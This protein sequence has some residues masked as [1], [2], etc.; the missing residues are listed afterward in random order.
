MAA[1]YRKILV[2]AWTTPATAGLSPL[3]RDV[4]H[5]AICANVLGILERTPAKIARLSCVPV[6]E[7]SAAL[8]ELVRRGLAD[9][10]PDDDLL[11]VRA[12]LATQGDGPKCTRA[13]ASVLEWMPPH[14]VRRVLDLYP[15]IAAVMSS[16]VPAESGDAG[17]LAP[18]ETSAPKPPS[19]PKPKATASPEIA[20]L[21]AHF[22]ARRAEVIPRSRATPLTTDRVKAIGALLEQ[23]YSA[24][25]V[26]AVI[27]H[28]ADR[29]RA[30]PEQA[31]W[32]NPST[33]WR[34]ENFAR[35][36]GQVGVPAER[37]GPAKD[38][39]VGLYHPTDD[40]WEEGTVKI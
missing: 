3:E 23:G 39:R 4:C 24:D 12:A 20:D 15:E 38:I 25:D 7:V 5:Q 16:P 6:R 35:T 1:R 28:Y 34:P 11:W 10:W 9:V 30:D 40:A 17:R 21:W 31:R 26:R 37:K 2:D 36:L 19:A 32:L 18:A 8:A 13:A 22:T 27:D 29:A 14:V 33:P